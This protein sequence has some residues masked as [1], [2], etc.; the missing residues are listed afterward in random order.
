[1]SPCVT[2][3][4]VSSI[5]SEKERVPVQISER[6]WWPVYRCLKPTLSKSWCD[7]SVITGINT[8]SELIQRNNPHLAQNK[9]TG[10][11]HM[12]SFGK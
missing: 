9:I 4:G 5:T 10:L 3:H 1:M 6:L 11:Y 2:C 12:K 7:N 8:Q